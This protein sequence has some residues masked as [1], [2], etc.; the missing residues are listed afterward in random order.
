MVIEELGEF[1]EGRFLILFVAM[2]GKS[3]IE[4]QIRLS[5]SE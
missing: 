3:V 1:Q 4:E 2:V 5:R